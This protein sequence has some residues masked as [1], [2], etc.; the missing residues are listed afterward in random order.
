M[1]AQRGERLFA[2][3]LKALANKKIYGLYLWLHHD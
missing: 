3:L 2:Y 1:W